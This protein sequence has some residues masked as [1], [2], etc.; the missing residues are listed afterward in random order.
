MEEKTLFEQ[1]SSLLAVRTEE[2]VG[3]Q[4]KI[5]DMVGRCPRL[6]AHSTSWPNKSTVHGL[7]I[8]HIDGFQ[9]YHKHINLSMAT[10]EAICDQ[11][12]HVKMESNAESSLPG[13]VKHIGCKTELFTAQAVYHLV[14]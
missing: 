11:F 7:P 6:R 12:N 8:V 5:T 3:H 4:A 13:Q 2:T 9:Y 1:R 10:I 14:F